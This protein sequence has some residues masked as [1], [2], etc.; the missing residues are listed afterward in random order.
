MLKWW[1]YTTSAVH[2]WL[3]AH[4]V[5]TVFIYYTSYNFLQ[6]CLDYQ[7]RVKHWGLIKIIDCVFCSGTHRICPVYTDTHKGRCA[8]PACDFQGIT[9]CLNHWTVTSCTRFIVAMKTCPSAS[10]VYHFPPLTCTCLRSFVRHKS[11]APLM[12]VKFPLTQPACACA[13]V[14]M[15]V[16][17]SNDHLW[18]TGSI[19]EHLTELRNGL[20]L[21][22]FYEFV[23]IAKCNLFLGSLKSYLLV[24]FV[25]FKTLAL[26]FFIIII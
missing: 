20:A 16:A 19:N 5:S 23:N 11:S 26:C 15:S 24:F 9:C 7:D 2:P 12:G 3:H 17:S 8:T 10:P 13:L 18:I 4:T 14:F 25:R 1:I 6:L 22:D 21:D